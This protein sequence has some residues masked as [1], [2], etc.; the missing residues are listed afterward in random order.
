MAR[1]ARR[2]ID[3]GW[4]DEEPEHSTE[5]IDLSPEDDIIIGRSVGAKGRNYEVLD[6]ATGETYHFVEGRHLQDVEVFAGYGS[7]TPL[8]DGVAEGLAQQYGG[9]AAQWQHVKGFGWLDVDGE[10]IWAEIHWFQAPG[11]GKVQFKTK[12]WF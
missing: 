1:Q 2:D 7:S 4:R 9:E 10:E 3:T 11:V 8:H 5:G 12:V 6:P